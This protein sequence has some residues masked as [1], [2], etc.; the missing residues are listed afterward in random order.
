MDKTWAYLKSYY[1]SNVET[2]LHSA[3]FLVNIRFRDLAVPHLLFI[4]AR[5]YFFLRFFGMTRIRKCMEL[6][7]NFRAKC[8]LFA[9]DCFDTNSM[10]I[11]DIRVME[12]CASWKS[13]FHHKTYRNYSKAFC[14]M[15][16]LTSTSA[17]VE[18]AWRSY[19]NVSSFNRN[20]KS[21]LTRMQEMELRWN[22]RELSEQGYI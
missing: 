1:S 18:Y 22:M 21:G 17:D 8:G 19:G 13:L 7:A 3:A 10:A 2:E 12:P 20:H 4:Q 16:E 11:E 5:E 9:M 15:I 6:I 14:M